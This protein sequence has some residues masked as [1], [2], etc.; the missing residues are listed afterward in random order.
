MAESQVASFEWK[1]EAGK[2]TFCCRERVAPSEQEVY[3]SLP[4]PPIFSSS[5]SPLH[6]GKVG[7]IPGQE[8]LSRRQ[9]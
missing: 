6:P 1:E 4:P 8:R 2:E 9:L 7:T 5:P 3:T